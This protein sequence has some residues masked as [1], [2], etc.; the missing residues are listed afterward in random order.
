MRDCKPVSR[1]DWMML[2]LA[3]EGAP[4][5]LHPVHV[6]KALFLLAHDEE[7]GLDAAEAYE[8]VPYNYGPMSKQIYADLDQLSGDGMIGRVP[9]EGQSWALFQVTQA[10]LDAARE[11]VDDMTERDVP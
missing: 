8:F 4:D 3:Y 10:G 1:R 6:Q 5:G 7:L 2:L 11:L 9:V